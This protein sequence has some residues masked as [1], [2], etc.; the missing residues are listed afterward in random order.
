[1]K[2]IQIQKHNLPQYATIIPDSLLRYPNEIFVCAQDDIPYGAIVLENLNKHLGITWLWVAPEKKGQKIGSAL[3]AKAY[4]F[5]KE[6]QYTAITI[7]YDP[8]ESWAIILEYMLAQMGFELYMAPFT[9]YYITAQMLQSSPLM[10]NY[11]QKE[12]QVPHTIALSSLSTK[13]LARFQF[14][15][16]KYNNLL[17]SHINFSKAAPEKTRLLYRD[18]KLIGLT[19]VNF[20]NVPGEYELS[21]V[22]IDPTYNTLLPTLF[23]ETAQELLKDANSFSAVYFT[24]V[25][26][27]TVR[28]ADALLGETKKTIKQ[29]C[30]GILEIPIH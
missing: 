11:H 28:L 24:C 1:M 17:L 21:M 7:A 27:T 18:D 12:N 15:C 25:V 30:H 19:L 20:A 10:K 6:N 26:N 13:E 3:L 2:I 5:A 4:Q 29:M 14:Q 16:Q 8:D 9:K 23:R 22:Y